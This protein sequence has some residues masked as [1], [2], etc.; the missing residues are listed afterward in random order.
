M[1]VVAHLVER[2]D[3][4]GKN[5]IN[6]IRAV[7]VGV[8]ATTY[9]SGALIQAQAAALCQGAGQDVPDDYFDTNRAIATTWDAD[10]D[11][12]IFTGSTVAETIA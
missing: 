1:A 11:I 10:E 12:T 6:G 2:A 7:I 4:P 9:T 3:A 8:E 5:F